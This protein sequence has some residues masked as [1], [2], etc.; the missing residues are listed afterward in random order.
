MAF[1]P[2]VA[3][4]AFAVKATTQLAHTGTRMVGV[5]VTA[6]RVVMVEF[7]YVMIIYIPVP[8]SVEG[9]DRRIVAPIVRRVPCHPSRSP[10]PVVDDGAIEID[11]FDNVVF[12]VEVGVADH[13]HGN[14]LV[15]FALNIDGSHILIYVF[16]K[17]GL[18]HYKSVFSFTY[19]DNTQI[20]NISVTI[21]VKVVQVSFLGVEFFFKL[22]EVVHFAKQS[23][24]GTKVEALG[25]VLI[26]SRNSNCLVGTC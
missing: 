26:G 4:D 12:A 18:E 19:F 2:V 11:G 8:R 16:S 9:I 25:D 3:N 24:Y 7:V 23:S 10:E 22:F 17:N 13:L 5:M 21:E 1:S 15:L 6:T 20:V 14:C